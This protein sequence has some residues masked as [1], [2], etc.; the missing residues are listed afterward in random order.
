MS[1]DVL[2]PILYNYG[3]VQGL[4]IELV[5]SNTTPG[6]LLGTMSPSLVSPNFKLSRKIA[7]DT[8]KA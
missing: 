3:G 1:H 2:R 8:Q 7:L 6:Q 4:G 5:E